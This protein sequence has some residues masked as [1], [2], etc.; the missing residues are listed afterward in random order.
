MEHRHILSTSCLCSEQT[1]PFEVY[2][3]NSQHHKIVASHLFSLVPL[4]SAIM[5]R[6]LIVPLLLLA[7]AEAFVE[8]ILAGAGGAGGGPGGAGAGGGEAASSCGCCN[9]IF[10]GLTGSCK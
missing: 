8:A 1:T 5:F 4:I 2:I 9:G 7:S 3:P 6:T 10:G